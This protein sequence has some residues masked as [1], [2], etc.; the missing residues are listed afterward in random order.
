MMTGADPEG[1]EPEKN[2]G[3]M[4]QVWDVLLERGWEK[5]V[6]IFR[7]LDD[8]PQ[9]AHVFLRRYF[10]EKEEHGGED[11]EGRETIAFMR[12]FMKHKSLNR[13]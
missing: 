4:E 10:P 2:H 3:Q 1:W 8:V 9:T 13:L 5:D 11:W 12:A 7:D 6:I